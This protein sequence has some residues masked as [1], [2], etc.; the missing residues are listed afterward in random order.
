M[1][2][3][4]AF[5]AHPDDIEFGCG[6]ILA[7]FAAEGKS[8]VM[9]DLTM[10]DKGSHGGSEKRRKESIEAARVIGAERVFL[11]FLDC[12]IVDSYEGR[13]KL[14]EVIRQ[15][16]PALV[17][18]PLWKGEQNHPDHLACGMMARYAC[19]YARFP[20]IL[21]HL[22]PHRVEGILHYVPPVANIVDFIIDISEYVEQWKEMMRCHASQYDTYPYDEWNLKH[23][24]RLGMMIDK[25]YAQALVKGNPIEVRDLMAVSRA[26]REL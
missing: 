8:V 25:P 15:Y 5:G 3:I 13:L 22:P 2:D 14:V 4:L 19:R 7:R 23:A 12:E 16:Q 18:A 20:K 17:L 9:I 11:N 24:A 21:P 1:V 26:C 6:G 10:G